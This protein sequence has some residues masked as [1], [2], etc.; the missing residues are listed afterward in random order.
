MTTNLTIRPIRLD[1]HA[2]WRRLWDGYNAFYGRSGVT[3]LPE[4]ISEATW[5]RFFDPTEPIGALVAS[6]E[7][8]IVGLAHYVFHRST[9]RLNR[10]CYLQ[11]LF[12]VEH[13][14]G[15]GIGR[16]LIEKV[17]ETARSAGCERVYWHTQIANEPARGLYDQ[18]AQ[19]HG[20]IVYTRDL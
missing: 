10:V 19:H 13:C 5:D 16:G 2:G 12:T 11:D 7:T 18:V 17:S 8:D 20:F 3:A 14:R 6:D 1:D 9:N 4:M 15:R